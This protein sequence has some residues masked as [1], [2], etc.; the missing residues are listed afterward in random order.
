MLSL[1]GLQPYVLFAQTISFN[2]SSLFSTEN[3]CALCDGVASPDS[4]CSRGVLHLQR[5]HAVHVQVHRAQQSG[6]DH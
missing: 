1:K 5:G 6:G 3:G 4:L 2:C